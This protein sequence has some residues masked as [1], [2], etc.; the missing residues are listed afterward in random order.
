[1][2]KTKNKVK[3]ITNNLTDTTK[4]AIIKTDAQLK[5]EADTLR[6]LRGAQD[7]YESSL[8]KPVPP[9]G[10]R[11]LPTIT[12]P[13]YLTKLPPV[14][15]PPQE[16]KESIAKELLA[17]AKTRVSNVGANL[18][19]IGN[20]SLQN[21]KSQVTDAY[22]GIKDKAGAAYGDAKNQIEGAVE[23]AKA[24]A[25]VV[26]NFKIPQLPPIPEFKIKEQPIP[27]KFKK[28]LEKQQALALLDAAK[29]SYAQA[30]QFAADT[31][32][33]LDDAKQRATDVINQGKDLANN[34]VDT[35]TGIADSARSQVEGA[36]NQATSIRDSTVSDI[37]QQ[38]NEIYGNPLDLI[39][40]K[41]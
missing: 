18:Q 38:A 20:T 28:L 6:F 2:A 26:K 14:T 4:S 34:A 35:A 27:R 22:A 31:Q 25:D 40:K 36:V 3:I 19:S 16:N 12:P 37:T 39:N 15:F 41:S 24:L 7:A 10:V 1:M 13:E 11:T 30:Q 32:A 29:E 17:N 9:L 33:Q 21:A 23:N 5:E 8:K